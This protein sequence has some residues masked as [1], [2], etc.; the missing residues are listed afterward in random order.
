MTVGLVPKLTLL[1]Y[2]VMSFL[3]LFWLLDAA[4]T[5]LPW[6]MFG[7]DFGVKFDVACESGCSK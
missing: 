1:G 6:L 3:P 7:R 4:P 2:Q 5:H